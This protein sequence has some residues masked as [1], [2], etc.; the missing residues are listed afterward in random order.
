MLQPHESVFCTCLSK[1]RTQMKQKQD[2]MVLKTLH[3]K[4]K[5]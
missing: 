1:Q 3:E 2:P 5:K 4:E